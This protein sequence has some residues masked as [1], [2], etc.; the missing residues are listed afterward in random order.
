MDDLDI[1][2]CS[3]CDFC[4][5]GADDD[6]GTEYVE[7]EMESQEDMMGRITEGDIREW[8][9]KENE[10]IE[11]EARKE[12]VRDNGREPS[13][14]ELAKKGLEVWYRRWVV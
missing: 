14:E 8:E 9:K 2:G 11:K 5:A 13:V 7:G 3:T 1:C 4:R 12:F 10:D 6:D